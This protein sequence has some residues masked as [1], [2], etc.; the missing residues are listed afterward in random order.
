MRDMDAF[1]GAVR[2]GALGLPFAP[3]GSVN[4]RRVYDL[5]QGHAVTAIAAA[6]IERAGVEL[7][8]DVAGLFLRSVG[9]GFSRYCSQGMAVDAVTAAFGQEGIDY[10]PLKSRVLAPLYPSPEWRVGRDV[11]ILVR[12][13]DLPRV[14]D[15]VCRVL[16]VRHVTEGHYDLGVETEEG[17]RIEFHFALFADDSSHAPAFCDVWETAAPLPDAPHH[18]AL[19]APQLYLYTVAHMAKHLQNGGCG[20]RPFL[21]LFYLRRQMEG[22]DRAKAKGLLVA[23]GLD[24]FAK[25]AEQLSEVFFADGARTPLLDRL[26]DFV[27]SNRAFGTYRSTAA[28]VAARG[29]RAKGRTAAF[30][31]RAFPSLRVMA[32]MYPVLR[33]AP[34]LLPFCWMLRAARAIQPSERTR[35]WNKVRADGTMSDAEVSALLSLYDEL[36]LSPK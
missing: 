33:R 36:G 25:Q 12:R 30:F 20:L 18:Y 29:K 28:A 23:A 24:R 17:V 8:G 14:R 7:P 27:L 2:A 21:D 4:W 11:D 13:S 19:P 5:A 35:F 26:A 34:A 15:L 22:E 3:D 10:M 1:L 6:G 9:A 32:F 16:S 31:S